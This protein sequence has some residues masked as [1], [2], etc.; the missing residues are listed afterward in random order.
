LRIY[1][2]HKLTPHLRRY[3]GHVGFNKIWLGGNRH[4]YSDAS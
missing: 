3:S 4:Q 1:L 2:G